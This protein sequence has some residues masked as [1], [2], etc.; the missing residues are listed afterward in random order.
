MKLI[1]IIALVLCI[2]FIIPVST[3]C[4]DSDA[5][6][7]TFPDCGSGAQ[8]HIN[9]EAAITAFPPDTVM[10]RSGDLTLSWAEF[11][12]VLFDI[13]INQ[14]VGIY[15]FEISWDEVI[16][17]ETLADVVME[18]S[19]NEALTFLVYR[20]GVSST[21]FTMNEQ[22]LAEI[23]LDIDSYIEELGSKEA[24]EEHLRQNSG[25]YSFEVFENI[26]ILEH[27]IGLL[28]DNLFGEEGSLFPDES[29]AEYVAENDLDLLMAL[30][31]VWEVEFDDS[32]A[33]LNAVSQLAEA[34]R[35]LDILK[36][37]VN[38]PDFIEFFKEMMLEHS[39]DPGRFEA[40]DGYLFT[41]DA[42]VP[43]FSDTTVGLNIG[44]LS[45][46][47]ETEYGYHIIFRAP[48]NYDSILFTDRGIS[49]ASLRQMAAANYFESLLLEWRASVNRDLERSPEFYEIDLSRIFAI[50]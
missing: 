19:V 40:P 12:I 43:E 4:R 39:E 7:C 25:V 24:L 23:T 3:A 2:V 31:I 49:P 22:D 30:H 1:R 26:I 33:P 45:G 42:M 9:F 44:E 47:V 29:V 28:A 36:G 21:G 20:Y 50:H 13:L 34:E 18:Y 48:V 6:I 16:D 10:L 17:E 38:S 41:Y 11:Y 32:G 15:G 27:S 35:V 46:I 5:A 8:P 14:L 37:R